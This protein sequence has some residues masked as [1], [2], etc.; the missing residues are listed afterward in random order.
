MAFP[1]V[2][3]LCW[4]MT[5][6]LFG[7]HW[8]SGTLEGPMCATISHACSLN[9]LAQRAGHFHVAC[10]VQAPHPYP[11]LFFNSLIR[12]LE[13]FPLFIQ[14]S[15]TGAGAGARFF[16]QVGLMAGL[17]AMYIKNQA[18]TRTTSPGT[19]RVNT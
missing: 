9:Y 17:Q 4:P 10:F 19:F 7:N 13:G 2:A 5:L 11:S 12:Y 1:S 15:V 14:F 6:G 8:V 18:C 16:W 3:F